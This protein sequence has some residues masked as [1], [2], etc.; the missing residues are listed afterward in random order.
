MQGGFRP[1]TSYSGTSHQGDAVDFQVD[2]ALVRA[3]R[4][5][6]IA[7]GDRT[8][9]GNWAPHV[10][11]VP[12]PSAGYAAGSAVWQWQDYIAKGGMNQAYNST[13]GL[14]EGGIVKARQGGWQATIGEGGKDE[15]VV[16]LPRNWRTDAMQNRGGESTTININGNLEFPNITDGSDAE[17]FV[18]NLVILAKD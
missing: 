9:L 13:W 3:F 17:E 5:V 16:P 1:R 7:A 2:Y 12:G 10:H 8:G 18:K 4:Q 14:A 15:A 11:A 6:G